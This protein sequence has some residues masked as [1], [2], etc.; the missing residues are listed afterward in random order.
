MS[1]KIPLLLPVF[2]SEESCLG[3]SVLLITITKYFNSLKMWVAFGLPQ[4]SKESLVH[5]S[6]AGKRLVADALFFLHSRKT[7]CPGETG[8]KLGTKKAQ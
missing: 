3:I 8:L 5:R 2:F 1:R 6:S 4:K 7:L